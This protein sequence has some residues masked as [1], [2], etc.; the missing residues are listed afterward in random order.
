MQASNTATPLPP[1]AL[2]ALLAA[3][4]TGAQ[5]SVRDD[6]HL[7][8]GHNQDVNHHGG[9]YKVKVIWAGFAGMPLVARQRAAQQAVREAWG[10]GQIHALTL[11]LLAPEE[12]A[13][14]R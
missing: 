3:A 9:H 2:H 5:I 7:H 11:Q 4:F 12:A 1:G 6:T 13:N 8:E 14:R 10:R